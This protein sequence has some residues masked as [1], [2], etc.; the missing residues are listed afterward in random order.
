MGAVLFSLISR[1]IVPLNNLHPGPVLLIVVGENGRSAADVVIVGVQ[2]LL[3]VTVWSQPGPI[4]RLNLSFGIGAAGKNLHAPDFP[5]DSL[6]TDRVTSSVSLND[7]EAGAASLV[8]AVD[9][10]LLA[11]VYPHEDGWNVELSSRICQLLFV[12]EPGNT[13]HGMLAVGDRGEGEQAEHHPGTE[14]PETAHLTRT[15]SIA[16]GHLC[17]LPFTALRETPRRRGRYLLHSENAA[18]YPRFFVRGPFAIRGPRLK[19]PA[20]AA[21]SNREGIERHSRYLICHRERLHPTVL[22][23]GG[24]AERWLRVRRHARIA[25]R[26]RRAALHHGHRVAVRI[27]PVLLLDRLPIG[28]HHKLIPPE[29]AHEH[30][31]RRAGKVEVREQA[32]HGPKSVRRI[33]E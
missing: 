32:V 28:A 14:Q 30:Q 17:A 12:F 15:D 25:S 19:L 10:R 3:L 16:N 26:G 5:A 7:D 2:V 8:V 6:V 29:R 23:S 22:P 24:E 33:N 9:A 31:Q 1:A 27:E 18:G 20:S 21:A 13:R 4:D 11:R